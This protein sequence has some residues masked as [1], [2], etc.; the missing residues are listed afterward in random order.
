[1]KK[2]MGNYTAEASKA[3]KRADKLICKVSEDGAIYLTSGYFLF[4]MTPLEYAAVAQPVTHCDAGDWT[5]DN[6]GK[7]DNGQPFT[8]DKIFADAV[9]ATQDTA[10]LERSPLC[11]SSQKTA[12]IQS[13][14]YNR[15]KDFAAFFNSAYVAAIAPGATLKSTSPTAPA[16][17]YF[18]DEAAALIMP[19][20]PEPNAARAVKAYFTEADNNGNNNAEADELRGQLAARNAELQEARDEINDLQAEICEL[21]TT[22]TEAVPA[23][24]NKPEPKT[25][26]EIIAA[27]FAGLD[28]V[29]AVIKG[30]QTAAPVVWLAGETEKH[31]DAIRAAG[32]KWSV[33]KGAY[34]VRV[35]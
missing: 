4:K 2:Y 5:I 27:R 17:V 28:G 35:A 8:A 16:I 9:K 1:M 29:R 20:R 30:A 11:F 19:I 23:A 12:V 33:K 15:D 10:A 21:S 24:D 14:F 32:A 18:G 34:Y 7:H 31:A 13:I 22:N 3:I 26:A 25:A 6:N